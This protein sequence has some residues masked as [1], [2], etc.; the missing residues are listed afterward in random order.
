MNDLAR[1]KQQAA[2]FKALANVARLRIVAS[3]GDGA[4]TVT[5]LTDMLG[6]D[7]STVSK[8]LAVLRGQGI[9]DDD[10]KGNNVF[11]RLTMPCVLNF[12]GCARQV[13]EERRG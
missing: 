8:H 7:Q 10:R 12:F 4:Q 2:V 3:L 5:Q 11:Y 9:V 6:L 13:I 1:F